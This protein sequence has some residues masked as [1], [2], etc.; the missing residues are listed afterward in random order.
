ML[1]GQRERARPA[2]ASPRSWAS[3]RSEVEH[4]RALPYAEV[5]AFIARLPQEAERVEAGDGV[6]DLDGSPKRGGARGHVVGDRR[7]RMDRAGPAHESEAAAYG[8]LE[9]P[10]PGDPHEARQLHPQSKLIFPGS[11]PGRPLSDMT[12]TK[13]LRDM[14]L[15]ERCTTHGMRSSFKDWCAEVAKVRNEVSEA[16]LAHVV[17]DKTESAYRRA[18][19]LEERRGVMRAWAAYCEPPR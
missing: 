11:Q 2:S 7:Q 3:A 10:S 17:K 8:A 13:L 12:L 15:A 1:R 4:Y 6:P 16:A 9:R 14:G 5:P 19:Y 18:E